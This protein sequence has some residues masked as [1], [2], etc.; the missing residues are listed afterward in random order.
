MWFLMSFFFSIV[1]FATDCVLKTLK[2][3]FLFLTLQLSGK[4]WEAQYHSAEVE[5]RGFKF[6]KIL[7]SILGKKCN[8]F[9]V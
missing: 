3:V 4:D 9:P 2:A 7:K 6:F 5:H 8:Y 1:L